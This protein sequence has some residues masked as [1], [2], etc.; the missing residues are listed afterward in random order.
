MQGAFKFHLSA[1]SDG[2]SLFLSS[3][4]PLPANNQSPAQ[5]TCP[6]IGFMAILYYQS[7]PDGGRD[8]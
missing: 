5:S 3:L 4:G 2:D 7:K 8:S 6:A 1:S